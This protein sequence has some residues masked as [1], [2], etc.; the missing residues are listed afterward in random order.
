MRR[1]GSVGLG[2]E[3]ILTQCHVFAQVVALLA[4]VIVLKCAYSIIEQL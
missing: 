1:N 4:V 2:R 3:P